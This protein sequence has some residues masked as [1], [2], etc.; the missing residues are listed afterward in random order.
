MDH[1]HYGL[2]TYF[3]EKISIVHEAQISPVKI[4]SDTSAH[5]QLMILKYIKITMLKL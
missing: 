2:D 3:I 4:V 1:G 5:K